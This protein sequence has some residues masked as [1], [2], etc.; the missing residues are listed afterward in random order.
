MIMVL[1]RYC[2]LFIIIII[3]IIKEP[4]TLCRCVTD[5]EP[6]HVTFPSLQVNKLPGKEQEDLLGEGPEEKM[7]LWDSISR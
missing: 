5:V 4:V 2:I 3:I 6:P 1:C 7:G